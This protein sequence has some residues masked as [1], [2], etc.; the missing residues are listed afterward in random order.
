MIPWVQVY[1]N[2]PMHPKTS[3]LAEELKLTSATLDPNVIAVGLLVS[4]WTWAI[5]NAYSGDLSECSARTIANACQWRKRPE[6]LVDALKKAGWLDG[7]MKLHD[8]DDYSVMYQ[9]LQEDIKSKQRK[10]QRR[11]R[12]RKKN[13]EA[14]AS[15][16]D[17]CDGERA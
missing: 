8:W 4:L 12:E 9:E 2:L 10:R 11:Y 16:C 7:D 13:S 15:P 17:D 5:Q 1:S 6:M 14:P 3:R